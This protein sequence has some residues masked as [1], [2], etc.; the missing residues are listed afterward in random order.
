MP[1]GG[2]SVWFAAL[3]GA[4]ATGLG[5]IVAGIPAFLGAVIVLLIGWGI[6]KLVQAL[7]TRGLHA[8]HFEQL[9]ERAGINQGLQR[10]DVKKD[11]SAI[12]G[13]V[14]YWFIFLIAVQAAVSLLGITALTSLMTAALLYIPRIF[15]ALV[16]VVVGAWGANLLG[17]LTRASAETAG[18]TFAGVL[19]S[20]V[21]G[22]VLFFTFAIALDVLGIAFPFLTTAFAVI[23]GGLA[24]TAAIAFGLGGREYAA[25]ILAGRELRTL[26]NVGDRVVI[27]DVDGSISEIRPTLTLIKTSRGEMAV[28]N[29]EMAHKHMTKPSGGMMGGKGMAA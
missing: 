18:I 17:R 26:F 27:D 14:A 28:Q 5:R 8:V 9:T 19:G 10:I 15:A 20:V 4:L 16:V 11:T 1:T 7:V 3:L 21:Q 24:L 6:G 23:L 2:V 13:I 29:S 12:L 22:A 25:D